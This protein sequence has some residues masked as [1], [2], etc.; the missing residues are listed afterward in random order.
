[1]T[2]PKYGLHA[3]VLLFVV[4]L[5]LVQACSDVKSEQP[6][7]RPAAPVTAE[8][9]VQKPVPV[10]I[11]AIGT[12]EPFSTV[13]VK[14]QVGGELKEVHFREGQDVKKGDLLFTIDPRPY[15]A[16]I[17]QYES[18]LAK[19]VAEMKNAKEVER[20]YSELVE[21][22]YVAK[23]EYDRLR[24][25]AEALEAVVKADQAVLENARLQLSYCFIHAPVEGRTGSLL[26]NEGNVIKA[27]ADSAMVVIN[28]IR[29]IYVSFS[30]P[31]QHL[32]DLGKFMAAGGL[33]VEA[34]VPGE[35]SRPE[36]GV[37][38]FLNNTVDT[39]TGTIRLK[40]TF[41]NDD[42]RLWPGQFVDVIL[43][44][45]SLPDAV[46]VPSQA[47]QTG[48]EGKYVFVVKEDRTV[49]T[50]P[51]ET[52]LI[53]E[54]EIVIEKGLSAGEVVVTDGQLRLSPGAKVEIR[55]SISPDAAAGAPMPGEEKVKAGQ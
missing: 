7:K 16:A 4:F 47:V 41:P 51:V 13:S 6:V 24:T 46:L 21:K 37:L 54:K 50:R 8:P 17:R 30:I 18:N 15:E 25:Q 44:L 38:T 3:S 40:G 28:R 2:K 1:M 55:E 20:R 43:N 34:S 36:Q 27:N 26:V 14:A 33:K 53:L 22:G 31:E 5:C 39:S 35:K 52:G 12:V 9:A 23:Q 49:E 48:Q 11:R 42:R 32:S 45:A 29:P 10:V 19:D